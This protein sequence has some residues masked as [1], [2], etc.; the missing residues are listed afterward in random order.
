M[1]GRL[2]AALQ[3]HSE[4]NQHHFLHG[5]PAAGMLVG[6]FFFFKSLYSL[7]FFLKKVNV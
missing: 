1:L 5:Q 2:S 7:L 3:R 6:P 4:E